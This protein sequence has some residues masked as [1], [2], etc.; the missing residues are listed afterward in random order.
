MTLSGIRAWHWSYSR[1][2]LIDIWSA[3][4]S[5]LSQTAVSSLKLAMGNAAVSDV[6]RMECLKG[7]RLHLIFLISVSATSP[8]PCPLNMAM[9][10]TWPSCFFTS[11]GMRWKKSFLWICK[12]LLS[13]YLHGGSGWARPKL[14]ALRSIWIIG[15]P[16]VSSRSP[17]TVPPS[18]SPKL[19]LTLESRLIANSPSATLERPLWQSQSP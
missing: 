1:S 7:Q 17:S 2:S 4:S 13:T 16:A 11:V 9:L 14:N 15:N 8:T 18:P 6:W 19:Q 10:M 12:V 5:T 3:S